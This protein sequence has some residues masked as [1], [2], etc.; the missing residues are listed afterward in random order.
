MRFPKTL[1]CFLLIVILFQGAS[2]AS[3][4]RSPLAEYFIQDVG[5]SIAK[6]VDPQHLS[7][8]Y[9]QKN[10]K[11]RRGVIL[12]HGFTAY[13]VEVRKLGKFLASNG[14][15]VYGVRLPGHGI[16][17]EAMLDTNWK[18]WVESVE[19]VY[20]AMKKSMGKVYLV[21]TSTGGIIALDIAAKEKVDGIVCVSA[22]IELQN[23]Y[24]DL[25]RTLV[26]AANFLGIN[27]GYEYWG[28]LWIPEKNYEK[29]PRKNVL[30]LLELIDDVKENMPKVTAP[31]LILQ[32]TRDRI[33]N[34]SS[35]EYIYKHVGS[36]VKYLQY[37]DARHVDYVYQWNQPVYNKILRF[38]KR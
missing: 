1:L 3:A 6:G 35:A 33:V 24:A 26:P 23:K 21:G 34:P 27:A 38:L 22:P 25:A 14:F 17:P 19:D 15:V 5:S 29:Y 30:E 7:F 12:I 20:Q 32:A 2:F 16:A 18:D 37:V 11:N 13:P 8:F 4:S 28:D 10:H 36:K 9:D 31:I